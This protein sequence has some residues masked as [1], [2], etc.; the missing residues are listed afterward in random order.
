MQ[1][2]FVDFAGQLTSCR[3]ACATW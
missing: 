2:V 3:I 1:S